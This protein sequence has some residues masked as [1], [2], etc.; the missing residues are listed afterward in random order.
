MYEYRS[1]DEESL[2]FMQK[3][4]EA[5]VEA[6]RAKGVTLTVELLGERPCSGKVD[7]KVIDEMSEKCM[8]IQSKHTGL[9]CYAASA[10]T[11]CNIPLSLG[12]PAVCLGSYEGAGVH[13]RE[14]KLKISSVPI[15]TK[16]VAELILGYFED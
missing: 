13:T 15:G 12:V 6:T 8:A 9:P 2:A 4:F 3:S 1:D 11:D 10:S 7:Q 14:E 16:I 5:I